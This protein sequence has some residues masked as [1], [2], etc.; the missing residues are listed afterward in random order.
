MVQYMETRAAR[1]LR[2][3][4]RF[5]PAAR[6]TPQARRH[7]LTVNLAD[8]E[9]CIGVYLSEPPDFETA[10]AVTTRALH[11]RKGERWLSIPFEQV[12]SVEVP[13]GAGPAGQIH[14]HLHGGEVHKIRLTV[15]DQH[16][17]D[18]HAFAIFIDVVRDDLASY[19][20]TAQ[21]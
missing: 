17:Q 14:V 1:Q 21:R 8:D 3:L 5:H 2:A 4:P 6:L 15:L 7:L 20:G 10:V 18:V 16:A 19:R 13:R 11:V 12:E 9:V